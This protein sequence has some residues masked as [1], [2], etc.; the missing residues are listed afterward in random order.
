M[1]ETH[2]TKQNL[3]VVSLTPCLRK[4]FIFYI[5]LLLMCR[6]QVSAH[7]MLPFKIT[8]EVMSP[9][10]LTLKVV[11]AVTMGQPLPRA[12]IH[13]AP[14]LV[15]IQPRRRTAGLQILPC[16]TVTGSFYLMFSN[17]LSPRAL[18]RW[19]TVSLSLWKIKSCSRY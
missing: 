4:P 7:F 18:T 19:A 9:L 17:T 6:C 8:S 10:R 16:T 11:I 5:Y 14:V 12:Y 2:P 3:Q 15:Q 1:S 13:Q